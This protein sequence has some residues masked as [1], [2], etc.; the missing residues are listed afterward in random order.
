MELRNDNLILSLE[1]GDAVLG[2]GVD[3]CAAVGAQFGSDISAEVGDLHRALL[4]RF[5]A[6]FT[7]DTADIAQL[8][9]HAALIVVGAAHHRHILFGDDLDDASRTRL[10]AEGTGAAFAVID[11]G[12]AVFDVDRVIIADGDAVAQSH[13]AVGTGGESSA[14]L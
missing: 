3:A 2:A 11:I 7:A 8:A 13:T 12:D 1:E 6:L 4:T 9:R 10:D 5:F 14:D